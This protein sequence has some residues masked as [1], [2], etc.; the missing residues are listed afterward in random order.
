[1]AALSS[2][3]PT[4]GG[5]T[6]RLLGRR[7]VFHRRRHGSHA[8]QTPARD[9]IRLRDERVETRAERKYNVATLPKEDRH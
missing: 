2:P 8:G 4:L 3:L 7:N 9:F 5:G 1:M 6:K